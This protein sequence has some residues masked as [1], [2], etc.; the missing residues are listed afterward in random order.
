MRREAKLANSVTSIN[1]PKARCHN[2]P[3]RRDLRSDQWRQSHRNNLE[4]IGPQEASWPA[5]TK[6]NLDVATLTLSHS[7]HTT[8]LSAS[9]Y[10]IDYGTFL[11]DDVDRALQW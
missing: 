4:N 9:S 11:L 10:E 7:E 2:R 5:A 8:P 3:I 1:T 6:P